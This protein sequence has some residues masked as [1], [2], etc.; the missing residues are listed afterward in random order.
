MHWFLAHVRVQEAMRDLVVM[1]FVVEVVTERFHQRLLE[2]LA[3]VRRTEQLFILKFT[4]P[5]GVVNMHKLPTVDKERAWRH[6]QMGIALCTVGQLEKEAKD[7]KDKKL[8][9][10]DSCTNGCAP[11]RGCR[12]CT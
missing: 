4:V 3:P 6:V 1:V 12:T 7:K 2:C 8:S 9:P 5:L 11:E 10:R